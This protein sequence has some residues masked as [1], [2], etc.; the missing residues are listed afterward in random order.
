MENTKQ[1]LQQVIENARGLIKYIIDALDELCVKEAIYDDR[2]R[3]SLLLYDIAIEHYFGIVKLVDARIYASAF[4]LL[5]SS[6][7][8]FIRASWIHLSATDDQIK[9]FIENDYI[10]PSINKLTEAIDTQPDFCDIS[11]VTLTT[12]AWTAMNSY[13]HS[14]MLQIGR[15]LNKNIIEPRY[16]PIEIIE[17]LKASGTFALLNLRQIARIAG[18]K[19]IINNID[20]MLSRNTYNDN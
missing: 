11:L 14:G 13:T 8:S 2:I 10:K 1:E 9:I 7:E 15:R 4:A 5:R 19:I 6:F 17:V 3:T 16:E 18:D 12:N 20:S